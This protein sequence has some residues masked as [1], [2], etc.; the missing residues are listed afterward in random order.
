MNVYT[1]R[2]EVKCGNS[3]QKGEWSVACHGTSLSLAKN[4]VIEGFK[5]GKIQKFKNSKDKEE[6][7]VGKGVYFIP[8]IEI[9]ESYSTHCN[10]V[11]C[12]FICRVNPE[13]IKKIHHNS[14]YVVN[15][16]SM[17]V[18]PYRLLV[19]YRTNK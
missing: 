9:S 12:V 4:L 11:L 18:I 5:K 14:I 15:K 19:K 3:G 7:I 17:D 16:P 2:W 8:I 13:E 10:G 6:G 1:K